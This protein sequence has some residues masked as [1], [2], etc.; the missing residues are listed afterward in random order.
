MHLL[1]AEAIILISSAVFSFSAII[2]SINNPKNFYKKLMPL[3]NKALG[4]KGFIINNTLFRLSKTEYHHQNPLLQ[5]LD[6]SERVDAVV[7]FARELR[8]LHLPHLCYQAFVAR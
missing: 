6:E 5:A 2:L 8:V 1:K 4:Y 3:K 7:Y